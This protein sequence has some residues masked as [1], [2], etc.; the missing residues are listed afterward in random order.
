MDNN[1]MEE[2]RAGGV[3]RSNVEREEDEGDA[4]V[5]ELFMET[6]AEIVPS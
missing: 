1:T 2:R 6:C 4:A 3:R 5:D